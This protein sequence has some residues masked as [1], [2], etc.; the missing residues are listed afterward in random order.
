MTK[1]VIA[2]TPRMPDAAALLAALHA[3]GVDLKVDTLADDALLQLCDDNGRPLLAIEAPRLLQVPGEAAR[4]LGP[5]AA[6]APVP[7]W[8]TE[9]R[10]TTAAGHS[11]ELAAAFA[12]SLVTDLGGLIWPPDTTP[13]AT[14]PDSGTMLA[15]PPAANQ[16]AVDVLTDRVAVVMQD[17]PTVAMTSW[18][19]DA[20]R[21]CL[22][23]GRGLQLVTPRHTRL[24]L[25]TRS[26]LLGQDTRWVVRDNGGYYD[27]LSGGQLHW[28]NGAF[29]PTA[30]PAT[31]APA[32]TDVPTGPGTQLILSFTT[33]LRADD[34]LV[35]GGALET[36]WRT[37]TGAAPSGWSTAE[38]ASLPWSRPDI[39][40]LA[41]DRA[42]DGTWYVTVGAP[43]Q[44]AVAT[45]R[46]TRT[47]DGVEEGI[48]LALGYPTG[49]E[50]PLHL[51]PEL[52]RTLVTEHGVQSAL[53]QRRAARSD[54]TIPN[55]FEVPPIPVAFVLGPDAVQQVGL[56]HAQQP[57]IPAQPQSLGPASRPGLHYPLGDGIDPTAWTTFEH[58]MR[59][60]R[61]TPVQRPDAD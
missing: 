30:V 58:L 27:G 56:S 59:H 3:T 52:A 34:D 17:R 60:L 33:Q 2:L 12:H 19:T 37:L 13:P 1:D 50:P 10:A 48:T 43:E 40:T 53:I 57:P 21:A 16:P 5:E 44:P 49:Q 39:T 22:S 23:S 4:L 55:H 41:H 11:G 8:W 14:R 24:T 46:V 47:T 28:A 7:C 35:L 25:A 15:P 6:D 45:T 26:L 29:E 20:L 36:A 61:R 9:T 32:F 31:V 38:P 51:L 18:L 42:P 54:L